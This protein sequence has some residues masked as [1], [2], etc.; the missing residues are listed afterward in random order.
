M[1]PQISPPA[2]QSSSTSFFLRPAPL[3][4]QST[5]ALQGAAWM[6]PLFQ[7]PLRVDS[8]PL[9]PA[10]HWEMWIGRQGGWKPSLETVLWIPELRCPADPRSGRPTTKGSRQGA[11]TSLPP[12]PPSIRTGPLE[13]GGQGLADRPRARRLQLA[14]QPRAHL[15]ATGLVG[16]LLGSEARVLWSSFPVQVNTPIPREEPVPRE[17]AK[18]RTRPRA[19]ALQP[20]SA[21]GPGATLH[22]HP[23]PQFPGLVWGR[24]GVSQDKGLQT[25]RG[26]DAAAKLCLPR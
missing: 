11:A 4:A 9:L 26:P 17:A 24:W 21:C 10:V 2:I 16:A 13:C 1:S 18:G 12:Q 25:C 19:T 23:A 15:C 3:C 20:W 5:S 7:L 6:E 22:Q 8:G 14:L